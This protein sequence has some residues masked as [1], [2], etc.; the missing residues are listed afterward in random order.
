MQLLTTA[1]RNRQQNLNWQS[2]KHRETSRACVIIKQYG[3]KRYAIPSVN[4]TVNLSQ[5][6]II[7]RYINSREHDFYVSRI[8]FALCYA[9]RFCLQ[10]S[11]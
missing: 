6:N 7:S 4:L 3:K 5:E 8:V 1:P 2:I 11:Q 10:H 9:I